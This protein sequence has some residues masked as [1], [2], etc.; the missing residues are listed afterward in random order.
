MPCSFRRSI[1]LGA[2]LQ[3][4]QQDV[5]HVRVMLAA[6]R[7]DGPA[8]HTRSFQW[9]QGLVI[10]VPDCQPLF[11]DGLGLFHLRP[12]EGRDNFTGQV[13]GADI[14]PRVLVHLAAEKLAAV[15]A[16]FPNDLGAFDK[17]FIIDQQ[18]AALAGDDVLGL[19]KTSTR[20]SGR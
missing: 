1:N 17:A 15:G 10:P 5:V 13:G 11:G 12:Q 2:L 14:H 3:R 6:V 9:R 7:N 19:V 4:L 8:K 18:S 16:L 20:P